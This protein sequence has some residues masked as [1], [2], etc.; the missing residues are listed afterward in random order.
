MIN[1]PK[2]T[3]TKKTIAMVA[4]ESHPFRQNPTNP[5]LITRDNVVSMPILFASAVSNLQIE[6]PAF[7]LIF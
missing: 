2:P 7:Y 5:Y 4:V 3:N 6:H 1:P